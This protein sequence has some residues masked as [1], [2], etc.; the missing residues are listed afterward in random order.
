MLRHFNLTR[1]PRVTHICS[2]SRMITRVHAREVLTR[3]IMV[4]YAMPYFGERFERRPF[5]MI[6][7]AAAL[8]SVPLP[9]ASFPGWKKYASRPSRLASWAVASQFL[10]LLLMV[11]RVWVRRERLV[12]RGLARCFRAN[13]WRLKRKA[14]QGQYYLTL[15]FSVR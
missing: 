13:L 15:V 4:R 7:D 3:K 1:L 10:L 9:R 5:G 6:A 14:F 12:N 2:M 11:R 8:D